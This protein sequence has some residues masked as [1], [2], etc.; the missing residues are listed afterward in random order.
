[1]LAA[2][3]LRPGLRVLD[4]GCGPGTDLGRMAGRVGAAGLTIGVDADPA[5]VAEARRRTGRPIVAGDAHA[6][7]LGDGSVDRIRMDRVVQH[8][9]DPG[10]AI[11]EA[12]RVLRGGGILAVAEPDWDTLVVDDPDVGTSRAYTQFVATRVVRNGAIGRAL[13]RLAAAAGFDRCA[14]VATAILYTDFGEADRI[15]KFD[16]VMGRAVAA[17]AVPG[18]AGRAWLSRVSAGALFASVTLVTITA[19]KPR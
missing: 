15:L 11:A 3:D 19:K 8:L 18:E 4:V 7:P 10:R 14:V 12:H 16:S 17:G 6:L 5:M 2:M 9:A 1:M 13:P